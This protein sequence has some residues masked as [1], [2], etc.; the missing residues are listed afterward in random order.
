MFFK[1]TSFFDPSA[2]VKASWTKYGTRYR[3]QNEL[4]LGLWFEL[5]FNIKKSVVKA[6]L[7]HKY[8][9]FVILRNFMKI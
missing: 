3:S 6:H 7:T 1:R 2:T 9:Y 4:K 5:W 8:G